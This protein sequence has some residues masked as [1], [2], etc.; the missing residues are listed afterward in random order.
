MTKKITKNLPVA[1]R[2]RKNKIL[3]RILPVF[4][5]L[6]FI[7][8]N[9]Y[10]TM[11]SMNTVNNDFGLFGNLPSY[12]I[13]AVLFKGIIDFGIF[14]IL[15]FVYRFLLGFSLY[16]FMIPKDVL[17]IKFRFWFL[18]RNIILGFV[19]NIRFIF[20]YFSIYTCIFE[21]LM[22]MLFVIMLYFDLNREYVEPLVG[23]F[24]FKTLAVPFVIYQAFKMVVLMWGVL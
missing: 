18:V 21:V 22:N 15:F 1:R 6:S 7:W 19:F 14:E 12:L 4:L 3:I 24:V 17:K 5:L 13:F 9:F 8:L 11:T 2:M 23:Q 16:S 10:T 20:P